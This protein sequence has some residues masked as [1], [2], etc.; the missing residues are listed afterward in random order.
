M[1]SEEGTMM[2]VIHGSTVQLSLAESQEHSGVQLAASEW[3]SLLALAVKHGWIPAGARRL[4]RYD[5]VGYT[6][7]EAGALVDGGAVSGY[8]S[9]TH[10]GPEDCSSLLAAWECVRPVPSG[11]VHSILRQGAEHGGVNL[12]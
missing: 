6:L 12:G 9:G 7:L 11:L 5:H 10:I 8:T 1:V 3:R 4:E 2:P